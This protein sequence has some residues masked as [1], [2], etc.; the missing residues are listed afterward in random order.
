MAP[1]PRFSPEEQEARILD[2][3][4]Q[5]IEETSLLDFT[6]AAVAKTAG[7]SMGSVYKHVRRKE[8]VLVALAT[9]MY[10]RMLP[11]WQTILQMPLSFPEHMMGIFL[12]TPEKMHQY[13]FG[14]HLE[15]LIINEA[16]LQRASTHWIREL[17]NAELR[18]DNTF[19]D[20]VSKAVEQGEL[21]VSAEEADT[22]REEMC[23]G[24]WSLHVGFW[25]VDYHIQT[26]RLIGMDV[27]QTFPL[28]PQHPFVQ[29]GCRLINSFPWKQPLD[30]ARIP[31]ICTLLDA[32][33]LR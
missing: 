7:I 1:A 24:L 20:E 30:Q 11:V 31:D 17:V 13:K 9:N 32:E 2:A 12:V 5:C 16:V 29:A 4:Q 14:V 26:R 21:L 28:D 6:M 25:Q 19:K 27:P 18:F 33:G 10:R 8:D 15:K 23:V 3:A 22:L